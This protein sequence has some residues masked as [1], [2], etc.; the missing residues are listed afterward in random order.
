M[1]TYRFEDIKDSSDIYRWLEQHAE[2]SWGFPGILDDGGRFYEFEPEGSLQTVYVA[3]KGSRL[4]VMSENMSFPE[5]LKDIVMELS[6]RE[7]Q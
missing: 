5:E 2:R 6:E 1:T 7:K 3:E 4:A